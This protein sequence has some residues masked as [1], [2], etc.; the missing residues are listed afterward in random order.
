[1]DIHP[2]VKVELYTQEIIALA[3]VGRQPAAFA[4]PLAWVLIWIRLSV[5]KAPS[6]LRV[7]DGSFGLPLLSRYRTGNPG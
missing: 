1:M 3:L 4:C 5:L 6:V 2:A 7:P